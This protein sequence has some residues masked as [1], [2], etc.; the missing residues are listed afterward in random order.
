MIDYEET[1]LLIN[2]AELHLRNVRAELNEVGR[3]LDRIREAF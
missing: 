3:A 1:I 2:Q